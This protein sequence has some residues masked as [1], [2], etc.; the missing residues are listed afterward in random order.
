M[1]DQK[2]LLRAF[3]EVVG[4]PD[5]FANL[6]DQL[7]LKCTVD[8]RVF[9]F[10][11]EAALRRRLAFRVSIPED[12]CTRDGRYCITTELLLALDAVGMLYTNHDGIESDPRDA[13]WQ[14]QWRSEHSV[15]SV[16]WPAMIVEIGTGFLPALNPLPDTECVPSILG[17]AVSLQPAAAVVDT[18]EREESS[19][20]DELVSGA[21]QAV[22][23]IPLYRTA[24]VPRADLCDH[25][26]VVAA[27]PPQHNSSELSLQ[28]F[29]GTNVIQWH[30]KAGAVWMPFGHPLAVFP[31]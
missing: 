24:I 2:G 16:E 19:H 13:L 7:G 17:L 20:L 21:A 4:N 1:I 30:I 6:R 3:Q 28:Q 14:V 25:P 12:E 27:R 23:V 22:G 29:V 26:G 11:H 31:L 10:L 18:D 15:L 5:N 9:I 8:G